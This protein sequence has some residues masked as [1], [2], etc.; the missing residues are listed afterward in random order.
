MKKLAFA[1]ALLMG[2]ASCAAPDPVDVPV[3]EP[4]SETALWSF[5]TAV[6][7]LRGHSCPAGTPAVEPTAIAIAAVP[8]NLNDADAT[9]PLPDS[10]VFAGGWR[11]TSGNVNFGG[12][13]GIETLPDGNLLTVSDFGAFV[14]IGLSDGYPDGTGN[15]AYMLGA[16]GTQLSGKSAGDAEGLAFRDGLALVSFERD[17]RIEAFDLANC[18]A[19]ARAAPVA[20][21]P[22]DVAG[23]PIDD[24]HGAEALSL[25]PAGTI[26]FGLESF[27]GGAS[28]LGAVLATGKGVLTGD[29]APNPKGYSLVG[30]DE[31]TDATGEPVSVTLY[32]S[33]DPIRGNRNII[34]WTRSDIE[35][36]LKRPM[37]V[38]NFEGIAA[39]ILDADTMRIWLISDN[40]F[41]DRQ[42]TLLFAFD[43]DT[44]TE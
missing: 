33:Y 13:S 12:L 17:H 5:D 29:M 38:D 43:I 19:N 20:G 36:K 26:E 18:G 44:R 21:L 24:N 15:L 40:N 25:Q 7:S 8:I 28:P 14:W 37:T 32:R 22:F 30:F 9:P 1:V 3:R 4:A 41:S 42:Q 2:L 35:I 16:D 31:T 6:Q 39:E 11:L 27:G 10:V 23:K 34:T